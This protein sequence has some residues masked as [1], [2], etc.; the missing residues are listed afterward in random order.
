MYGVTDVLRSQYLLP[1]AV[2]CDFGA[3]SLFLLFVYE[4][5]REPLNGFVPNSHR[6]RAWSIARTSL[7]VKVK[8]QSHQG[9]NNGIFGPSAACVRFMFVKHL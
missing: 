8:G 7:K 9:Q 5:Y 1:H 4:M 3:V 6:R 2:N